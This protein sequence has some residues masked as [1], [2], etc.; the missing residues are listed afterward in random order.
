MKRC[1]RKATHCH[2]LYL[3]HKSPAV[4]KLQGNLLAP[5][6]LTME[7]TKMRGWVG[8]WVQSWGGSQDRHISLQ[9]AWVKSWPLHFWSASC[10]CSWEAADEGWGSWVLPPIQKTWVGFPVPDF[11]QTQPNCSRELGMNQ[12]T[13][14]LSICFY[15]SSTVS[16]PL[17]SR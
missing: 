10:S 11:S 13:E 12:K 6:V 15:L 14:A 1:E 16:L 3:K 7:T 2:I 17:Q 9:G 5:I 8:C 4:S